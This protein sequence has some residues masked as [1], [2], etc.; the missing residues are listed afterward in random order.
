M[1]IATL[2]LP[3]RTSWRGIVLLLWSLIAVTSPL[4]GPLFL[5]PWG[6][7]AVTSPLIIWIFRTL[8]LK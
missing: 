3:E 2:F 1:F 7:L 6:I 4:F 5:V 8:F